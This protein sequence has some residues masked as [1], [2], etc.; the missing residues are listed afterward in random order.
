MGYRRRC[1]IAASNIS[2]RRG[3]EKYRALLFKA[4]M[5]LFAKRKSGKKR[6]AG[7]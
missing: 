7:A 6:N 1:E 4:A 5:P 3:T 2:R